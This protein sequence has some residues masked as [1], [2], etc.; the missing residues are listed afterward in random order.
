MRIKSVLVTLG[1]LGSSSLALADHGYDY[2]RDQRYRQARVV[3]Q[4]PRFRDDVRFRDRGFRDDLAYRQRTTWLALTQAQRLERGRDVFDF[5][6]SGERFAQLRLQNQ[7]GRTVVRTIEIVFANG[8]RQL[9]HVNQI[10]EGNHAMVN[11]DIDGNTRRIARIIVDGRS[12]R[13]ASY[14]L[15]A[16]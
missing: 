16:M 8:E 13:A 3:Q 2:T 12:G 1:I 9:V 11:I 10:L 6:Y 14:Q 4:T 5:G 15:Y 7:T